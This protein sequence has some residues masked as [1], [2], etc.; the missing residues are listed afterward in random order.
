MRAALRFLA[1]VL[2]V[3]GAMLFLDIALTLLW[4]EPISAVYGKIH[5][6]KL[7]GQLDRL[8]RAP[9][10]AAEVKLLSQL[11]AERRV[12]FLARALERRAKPGQ[13]IGRIRI[14]SIGASYVVVE[15]T[16]TASLRK[17]PGHYPATPFPGLPGTVGIA[18]HRTTYLAPFRRLDGVHRGD[19]VTLEMPY[20][21]FTYRVQETRIVLPTAVQITRSVGYPRLVLTACHPLYS[22]SHRIA[23]F[24]RLVSTVPT[25]AARG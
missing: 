24:A 22:A 16:D 4:Q 23:L 20:A 3:T 12:A 19:E 8:A 11:G 21:R 9:L 7:D 13:A 14:A 6:D 15:G 2:I 17:G 1:N 25:G 10:P 5:Q 18:G